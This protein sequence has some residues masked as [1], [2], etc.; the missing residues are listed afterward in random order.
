VLASC[1]NIKLAV[2]DLDGGAFGGALRGAASHAPF[3]VRMLPSSGAGAVTFQAL[4]A[5]VDAG[6]YHAALTAEAGATAALAAALAPG[7]PPFDVS[8][9][10]T[11]VLDEGRGGAVMASLLRGAAASLVSG[12]TASAERLL[13]GAPP[14]AAPVVPRALLLHTVPHAGMHLAAGIAFILTWVRCGCLLRRTGT[15]M[16]GCTACARL[17]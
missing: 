1:S 5:D 3:D 7:G 17:I 10:S 12:A 8:A 15:R 14:G 16:H 6:K 11:L 9:A 4:L 13:R 2:L